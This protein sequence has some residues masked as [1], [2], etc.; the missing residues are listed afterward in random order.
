MV[1]SYMVTLPQGKARSVLGTDQGARLMLSTPPATKTSPSPHMM[2]R[3]AWLTAS[4][5][6]AHSRLT[7]TPATLKGKPASKSAMRATLRLS[8][9]A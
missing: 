3:A 5:P 2:A 4:S 6:E 1:V 8:S 9:P 7:V